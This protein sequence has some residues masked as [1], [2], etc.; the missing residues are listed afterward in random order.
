MQHYSI[1]TY[2]QID[3]APPPPA[4]FRSL[5]VTPASFRLQMITLKR[6]GYQGVSM[7]ELMPYVRGEKK[8]KV[9]GLT[10]DDGYTNNLTNALPVLKEFDFT[11]T[12]YVVSHLMGQH[13][14][15]DTPNGVRQAQL[16][17]AEQVKA[18]S[19]AGMEVGAHTQNHVDLTQVDDATAH[20]E[21]ASSRH[22]LTELLGKEV[23]SFCYPFGFFERRHVR[24]AQEAG[25]QS[26]TTTRRGRVD[27]RSDV[28]ELKR[29]PIVRSTYWPQF[30]LKILTNYEH[31]KGAQE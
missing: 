2:H 19:D 10:F 18:W 13:N 29:I 14:Q 25:Y 3:Q 15:W 4:T 26:A 12:C 9:I 30:L 27:A 31:N 22:E 24:M 5:Y 17:S 23:K 28:F 6:L 1:L 11:A 21:I 7:Q 8:G 20:Q 16:M